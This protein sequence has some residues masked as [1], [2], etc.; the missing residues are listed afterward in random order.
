MAASCT[1]KLL[2]NVAD[3]FEYVVLFTLP[4]GNRQGIYSEIQRAE[5]SPRLY[6]YSLERKGNDNYALI[7][8]LFCCG[9]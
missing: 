6:S 9:T 7:S 2:T 3:L 8:D 5:L 4:A 1:L